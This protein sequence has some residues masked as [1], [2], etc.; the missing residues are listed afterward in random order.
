MLN[1]TFEGYLTDQ[2]NIHKNHRRKFSL[3]NLDA[4][5]TQRS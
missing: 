4:D 2:I 1:I 5:P 3:D